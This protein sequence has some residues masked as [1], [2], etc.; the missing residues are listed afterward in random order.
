VGR[1]TF[2]VAGTGHSG[3]KDKVVTAALCSIP[4]AFNHFCP[5]IL[6]LPSPKKQCKSNLYLK[7]G[8]RFSSSCLSLCTI[9]N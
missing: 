9:T 3:E 1:H 4:G 8:A 5:A 6:I 7:H 2:P